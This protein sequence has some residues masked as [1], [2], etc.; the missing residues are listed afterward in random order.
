MGT[1]A[2]NTRTTGDV[3]AYDSDSG[4]LDAVERES[5]TLVRNLELLRRRTSSCSLLDQAEYLLLRTVT[6]LGAADVNTLACALG[7]DPSTAG[8]QVGTMTEK[9]LVLR[10]PDPADRRRSVIVASEQ[11]RSRMAEVRT[12]REGNLAELLADWSPAERRMLAEMFAKY[13]KTV[14]DRYITRR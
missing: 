4:V 11:G 1:E 8:R 7:L 5:A 2:M 3:A 12:Q 6:E 10:E 14:I 13:N 9:G